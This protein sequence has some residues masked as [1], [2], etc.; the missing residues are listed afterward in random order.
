MFYKENVSVGTFFGGHV[1]CNK[2]LKVWV[3]AEGA[4]QGAQAQR[5]LFLFKCKKGLNI[6]FLN[7]NSSFV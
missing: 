7:L 4:R 2:F 1:K 3:E 6:S 5:T